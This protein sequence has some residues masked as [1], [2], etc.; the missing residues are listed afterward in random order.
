[1]DAI[2]PMAQLLK[3][4]GL[5]KTVPM[6]NDYVV[7]LKKNHLYGKKGVISDEGDLSH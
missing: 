4:Q 1:M 5:I 7:E 3:D 2:V 6:V